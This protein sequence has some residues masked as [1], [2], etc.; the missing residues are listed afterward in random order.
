MRIVLPFASVEDTTAGTAHARVPSL[1][2]DLEVAAGGFFDHLLGVFVEVVV[3]QA[4]SWAASTEIE[5]CQ[6]ALTG[7]RALR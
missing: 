2:I 3:A 1:E 4:A 5:G 6:G 7:K